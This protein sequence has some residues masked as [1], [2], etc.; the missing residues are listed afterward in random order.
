MRLLVYGMQS[1]GATAFTL[2]LAQRPDCLALVDVLNNYAAPRVQTDMDMVVKVTMTTAYPLAVHMERFRPDRIVLV[3]RD[4]HD[5]YQSLRSKNYRNHSGLLDEKFLILD[6][7]FAERERF[8]AVIR[9]EDFVARHPSVMETVTGLGWPVE[10]S[11]HSYKRRHDELMGALWRHM[12][13]LFERLE[14]NFGNVQGKEVSE[15][16]RDKPRDPEV[17]DRLRA[18]CPRT[19]AYYRGSTDKT[20][21][22]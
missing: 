22:P 19:L 4:P 21:R 11:F 17:E 7:V 10:D 20:V 13:D 18:L 2:F 5:N 16:F 3:L 9:Y 14:L 12:P 6:Q 1:S 15:H 8:D